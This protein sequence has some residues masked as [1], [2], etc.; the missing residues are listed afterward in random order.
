MKNEAPTAALKR[1]REKVR[2]RGS[3]QS[4]RH[5]VEIHHCVG[6]T[7][8]HTDDGATPGTPGY[9]VPIGHL[10]ILPLT[11]VEHDMMDKLPGR[12]A[13]EKSLFMDLVCA[14]V[15]E[16]GWAGIPFSHEVFQIIQR[17]HK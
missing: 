6:R 4:G 9:K 5:P 3:I 17:Y 2:A 14:I 7:C 13:R 1:W 8:V 12:K 11:Q 16:E 15:K 10:W